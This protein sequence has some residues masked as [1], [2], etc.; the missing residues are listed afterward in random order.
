MFE[1]R[2]PH[3]GQRRLKMN[4]SF[5]YESRDINSFTLLITVKTSTKLNLEHRNKFA[6][7]SK[8]L[9]RRS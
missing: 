7:E 8:K 3:R 6:I 9:S 1:P 2:R 4:F 5:I